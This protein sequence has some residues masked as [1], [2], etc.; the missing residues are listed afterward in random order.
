[1]NVV[2]L[3]ERS[4]RA[5]ARRAGMHES[6][7]RL[8]RDRLHVW[9]G[10]AGAPLLLLHGFGASAIWQ[11]HPQLAAFTRSRDV[12]MPDLLWF[13]GSTSS[14][15]DASLDHQTRAV[16]A[17]LDEIGLAQV[18]VVGLSYGGLVAYDLAGRHSDRVRRLVLV[19]S[20]AHTWTE[21]DR[22]GLLARFGIDSL[23]D[24]FIPD[25]AWAIR[26]LLAIATRRPPWL[27]AWAARQAIA[28]LYDP[29][30]VAQTAALEHLPHDTTRLARDVHRPCAP[31]LLVW[32]SED[33]V[34]PLA[35]A[36]R[37]RRDLGAQLVAFDRARHLPNAE[38][39]KR[40]SEVVLR[41][42][43]SHG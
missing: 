5:K 37:L 36:H 25:S 38:I 2:A 4:L 22:N 13:G 31:T 26:T 21:S 29:H 14:D 33:P 28:T 32:G 41:F 40:F 27:P 19:S 34:F 16:V 43:D 6:N 18:D 10:G 11:W 35:I 15:R 20:P 30:R 39:P 24:L 1:M 23:A 3:R 7:P 9:R 42:L 17:L 8:G 12:V